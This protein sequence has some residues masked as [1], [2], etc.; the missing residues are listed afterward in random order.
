MGFVAYWEEGSPVTRPRVFA[1]NQADL[2][3]PPKSPAVHSQ[4]TSV[5]LWSPS[6]KMTPSVLGETDHIRCMDLSQ[7]IE[8]SRANACR[9]RN[10]VFHVDVASG[11]I[12]GE[13]G[14]SL[15]ARVD[16]EVLAVNCPVARH[17]QTMAHWA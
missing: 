3:T 4:L 17:V 1:D 9:V 16:L 15:S 10:A 11:R 5:A 12:A 2:A 6:E 13:A 7:C 8:G 14:G